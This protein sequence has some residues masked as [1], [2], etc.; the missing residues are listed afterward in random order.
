MTTWFWLPLGDNA[1]TWAV[2]LGRDAIVIPHPAAAATAGMLTVVAEPALMLTQV[3][4]PNAG[5][6]AWIKRF[7]AWAGTAGSHTAIAA[8]TIMAMMK[9]RRV[10]HTSFV[11]IKVPSFY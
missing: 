6:L 2:V 4:S 11:R 5:L 7:R 1:R 8:E 9:E 3:L 10:A